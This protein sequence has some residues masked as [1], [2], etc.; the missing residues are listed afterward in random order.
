MTWPSLHLRVVYALFTIASLVLA[1]GAMQK[2]A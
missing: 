2:W 1:S